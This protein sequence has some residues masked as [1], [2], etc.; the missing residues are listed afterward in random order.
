MSIVFKQLKKKGMYFLD[1]FVSGNSVC[2]ALARKMQVD[3]AKRDIFIDNQ[4]DP[5]DIKSQIFKLKLK[6][7][8]YGQAIGIGHDHKI[9]LDVLK[10]VMPELE[11]QGYKF[12]FLSELVR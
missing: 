2:L 10:E 4:N 12:V 8:I 7:R 9:T 1:S 11:K 3:F 6:A 5:D